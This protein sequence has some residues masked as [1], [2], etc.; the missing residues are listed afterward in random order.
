M[1]DRPT[2]FFR[3]TESNPATLWD[4][5]SSERRGRQL[6]RRTPDLERLFAGLSVFETLEQARRQAETYPRLGRFIAEIEIP[7]D[8]PIE[9][10]RTTRTEGHWT[11][12][13][14]PD[15]LLERIVMV[16]SVEA[17]T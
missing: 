15:Y 8:A 16:T 6:R 1:P 7:L 2:R 14:R 4:F 9:C 3:V 10:Q 12:W 13:A 17:G 11:I 5:L